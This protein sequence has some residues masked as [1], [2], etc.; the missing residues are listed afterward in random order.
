MTSQSDNPVQQTDPTVTHGSATQ[1]VK[2][3]LVEHPDFFE[4]HPEVLSL[5][6]LKHDSGSATSLLE[7]QI[8][9]LRKDNDELQNN[10]KNLIEIAHDNEILERKSH[11]IARSLVEIEYTKDIVR[12]IYKLL[13]SE[14]PLLQVRILLQNT[15]THYELD[16]DNHVSDQEKTSE[17]Y[18]FILVDNNH[19]CVFLGEQTAAQ[20][21]AHDSEIKSAVA[22]PLR[23]RNNFGILILASSD[24]KRFYQGMGT[25]FLEYL[26]DLLSAKL[27]QLLK[28]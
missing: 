16:E 23:D 9:A 13:V 20:L 24:E 26:A 17:L 6:S 4:Q 14:F 10:I 22:I 25:L 19:E 1:D 21:F 2:D 7:R 8:Q 11:Q 15:A 3:Y 28:S 12:D 18:Q 5:I 27:K